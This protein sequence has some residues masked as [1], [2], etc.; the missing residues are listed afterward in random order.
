MELLVS[1]KNKIGKFTDLSGK[2]KSGFVTYSVF[3]SFFLLFYRLAGYKK[4]KSFV[5]YHIKKLSFNKKTFKKPPHFTNLSRIIKYSITNNILKST[6]LEQSIFTYYILGINGIKS[7]IK[8]GVNNN[9][10]NF[11][12]H[13]WVEK[14]N[15]IIDFN[16]NSADIFSSF[17]D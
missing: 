16:I 7:K 10:N 6:C 5:D 2:E 14:D 4:T 15:K 17:Q 3:F 12:A 13:A 1:I 8:F 9:I 11:M